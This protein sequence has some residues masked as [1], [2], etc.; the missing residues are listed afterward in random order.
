[1]KSWIF[2]IVSIV[3]AMLLPFST[4]V[5]AQNGTKY[6]LQSNATEN[7]KVWAEGLEHKAAQGNAQAQFHLSQALMDGHVFKQSLPDS[8]KWLR[9]AAEQ[10]LPEAE[11]NMGGLYYLGQGLPRDYSQAVLW[12]QKAADHGNV[13][14][15][16]N[17]GLMY[18]LGQGVKKNEEQ[19]VRWYLKSAEQGHQVAAYGVGVAYWY[20]MGVAQD[21]VKGYMWL[22]L[23][24]HFGWAQGKQTADKLAPQLGTVKAGEAR[25]KER[26]WLG[27]HPNVKPVPL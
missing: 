6:S 12:T 8:V 5:L 22:L 15:E 10:G 7:E 19:A 21:Q 27:T 26:E 3:T 17:L 1:M 13:K 23:A 20:G 9:A 25:R 14:G 11:A 18:A 2:C 16:Y 24:S 4:V